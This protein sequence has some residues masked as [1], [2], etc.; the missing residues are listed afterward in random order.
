[1][2]A[3]VHSTRVSIK[4]S[5]WIGCPATMG[6]VILEH[7]NLPRPA[8]R[9]GN[10][11][12][13]TYQ[14]LGD[15]GQGPRRWFVHESLWITVVAKELLEVFQVLD[16]TRQ[17]NK[18]WA[19]ILHGPKS[20]H[21]ARNLDRKGHQP[22]QKPSTGQGR[23]LGKDGT[24]RKINRLPQQIDAP[25]SWNNDA[26]CNSSLRAGRRTQPDRQVQRYASNATKSKRY[27][28]RGA[29]IPK[30]MNKD[31]EEEVQ[32]WGRRGAKIRK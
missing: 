25:S 24:S 30:N 7:V 19:M 31:T 2:A 3:R 32:R 18:G 23:H 14:Q 21:K 22:Q 5:S 26:R 13:S 17:A 11:R 1:M 8:D 12:A 20:R 27:G 29:K 6:G 15:G 16:S 10:E 28:R 4:A 9:R